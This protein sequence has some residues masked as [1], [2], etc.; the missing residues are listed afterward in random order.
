MIT[1]QGSQQSWAS[2]ALL[3][4]CASSPSL[5]FFFFS[6]FP[7]FLIFLIFFPS[8][9]FN[10][11]GRERIPGVAAVGL[12]CVPR[13]NFG[14]LVATQSPDFTWLGLSGASPS[15]LGVLGVALWGMICRMLLA[16]II[17]MA[18][19]TRLGLY[20]ASSPSSCVLGWRVGGPRM[21]PVTRFWDC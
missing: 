9:S 12:G 2:D 19:L 6:F 18:G 8:G 3:L 1:V 14:V 5:A 13:H 11:R 20:G 17:P 10:P 7:L 15:P 21:H 4:L 16:T